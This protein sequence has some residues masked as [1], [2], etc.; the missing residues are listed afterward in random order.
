M[1]MILWKGLIK[2]HHLK[3]KIKFGQDN[4]KRLGKDDKHLEIL[5][6]PLCTWVYVRKTNFIHNSNIG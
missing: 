5:E 2:M 1:K 3:Y 4:C 6:D